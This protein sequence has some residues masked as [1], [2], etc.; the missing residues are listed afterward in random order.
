[1]LRRTGL[2]GL[3]TTETTARTLRLLFVLGTRPEAIKMAPVIG[4]ARQYADRV[5]VRVCVTGQHREMLRTAL[6]LFGIDPDH[7]LAVM[8]PA[9]ALSGLCA[10]VLEGLDELLVEQ[11]LPDWVIVQGD[12]STAMAAA[13]AAF[14]RGVP[15]AHVE[16]GLRTWDLRAPFPEELNRQIV[17]RIASM[18]FAPTEWAADNLRREGI[19]NDRI[20]VT[21]NTVI[22]AL[23][24]VRNTRSLDVDLP[25]RFP[26]LRE[27]NR[28]LLLVTGHRRENFGPGF[29][30][31]CRAIAATLERWPDICVV[32]PVHL[33][34]QVR[35][36]VFRLLGPHVATG[37]LDL[38]EPVDYVTFV[39][40]LNASWAVLTDSGGV[41][42]EAPSLGKPV[43]CAREATERPEGVAAGVVR[44]V[45]THEASII[46]AIEELHDDAAVYAAMSEPKHPYGDGHASERILATLLAPEV[47]DTLDS[48]GPGLP[49]RAA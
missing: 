38:V 36:P 47:A 24:Q 1:M 37:R 48:R 27:P 15:V 41:Q 7:D 32:Y 14:H 21:G 16:A 11:G 28:K 10:R 13:L 33:N 30:S 25:S 34:P 18:H 17:G 19:P 31:F 46:R 9:Q 3:G 4:L 23:L 5:R 12:T 39:G 20:V 22:D 49:D 6:E 29:E 8:R 40:L 26:S 43:L 35:E 2:G 45:G 44:L 42:E